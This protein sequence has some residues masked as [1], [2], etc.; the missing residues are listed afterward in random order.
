[1]IKTSIVLILLVILYF[2]IFK[3][4][5]NNIIKIKFIDFYDNFN[6]NDN[7]ITGILNKYNIKYKVV[8]EDPDF[9][10]YSVFG[11]KHTKLQKNWLNKPI[12]IFYTAESTFDNDMADIVIGFLPNNINNK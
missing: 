4:K 10:I 5:Y 12:F 8:E 6:V 7:I 1:M 9:I 3:I 2:Y 11:D